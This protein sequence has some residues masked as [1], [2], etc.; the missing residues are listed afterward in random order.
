MPKTMTELLMK[1]TELKQWNGSNSTLEGNS[2]SALW[3]DK[4]GAAQEKANPRSG[5]RRSRPKS[6]ITCWNCGKKGH[7]QY[8]CGN[9]KRKMKGTSVNGSAARNALTSSDD[10]SGV[11]E[12]YWCNKDKKLYAR[13]Q[14]KHVCYVRH[15]LTSQW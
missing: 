10:S 11:Q 9:D 7:F 3:V 8:E 1:M 15:T 2:H 13:R 4:T 12:V 6:T 5:G 14:D